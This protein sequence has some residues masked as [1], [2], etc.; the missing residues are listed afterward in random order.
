[1]RHI[2]ILVSL[3]AL[4]SC[5]AE[6]QRI[7]GKLTGGFYLNDSTA[8]TY[9]SDGVDTLA[10]MWRF[11]PSHE[12]RAHFF[13][14][15]VEARRWL[16]ALALHKLELSGRYVRPAGRYDGDINN[17]MGWRTEMLD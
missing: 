2:V 13:I 6:P 10:S 7:P 5:V 9:S 3:L 8:V 4:C 11:D 16:T 1:M 14:R 12:D 15:N 17:R